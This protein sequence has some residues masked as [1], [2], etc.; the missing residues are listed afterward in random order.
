MNESGVQSS[1]RSQSSSQSSSTSQSSSPPVEQEKNQ[2]IK[3][4]E[5]NLNLIDIEINKQIKIADV[6]IL[7]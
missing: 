6:A 7:K 3:D 4:L 5:E 1:R 2:I